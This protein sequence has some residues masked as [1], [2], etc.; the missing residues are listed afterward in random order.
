MPAYAIGHI[1][2]LDTALWD[3]YRCKVPATLEGT[4]GELMFRA[5]TARVLGGQHAHEQTVV[6]CFPDLA[7]LNGWFDSPAYQVLIPLRERA[8]RVDL[9]GFEA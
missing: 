5:R 8:A 9:I 4:G 7:A 6:I 3:E 2:V 1:T